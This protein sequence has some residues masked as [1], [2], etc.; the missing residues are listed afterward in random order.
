M[1]CDDGSCIVMDPV[2]NDVYTRQ[3]QRGR[4]DG[5]DLVA[6]RQPSLLGNE[7]LIRRSFGSLVL[8]VVDSITTAD[9]AINL[10]FKRSLVHR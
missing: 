4:P 3:T 7:R 2:I 8:I 6:S 10:Y 5:V 1:I 9:A